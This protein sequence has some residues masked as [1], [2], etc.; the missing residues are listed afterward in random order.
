MVIVF[1]PWQTGNVITRGYLMILMW[2]CL[3]MLCTPLYPMV[4]L[5]IIPF[6]NGYFIGNI[7]LT[8]SDKPMY[9]TT[10]RSGSPGPWFLAHGSSAGTAESG[11][12][13]H[14][15]KLA[16]DFTD[17]T[18]VLACSCCWAE[19]YQYFQECRI[20]MYIRQYKTGKVDDML[21]NLLVFVIAYFWTNSM[22]RSRTVV[23]EEGERTRW[24]VQ[25]QSLAVIVDGGGLH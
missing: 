14:V 15:G 17:S 10:D 1:F 16:M 21:I 13:H 25:N 8:F 6:L 9:T 24:R 18:M 7:N 19:V 4:L 23:E 2:G 5:I 20:F 11:P 3:K 12:A 22:P